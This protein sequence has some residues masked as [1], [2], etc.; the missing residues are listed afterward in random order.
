MDINEYC[1]ALEDV[2]AAMMSAGQAIYHEEC[3]TVIYESVANLTAAYQRYD[4]I[5]RMYVNSL[6]ERDDHCLR[7]LSDHEDIT[8]TVECMQADASSRGEPSNR[9]QPIANEQPPHQADQIGY[10]PTQEPTER[11]DGEHTL[12][13][14]RDTASLSPK[15]ERERL[16]SEI[17]FLTKQFE[18]EERERQLVRDRQLNDMKSRLLEITQQVDELYTTPNGSLKSP[19]PTPPCQDEQRMQDDEIPRWRNESKVENSNAHVDNG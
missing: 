6:P 2:E 16:E 9:P 4:S 19:S 5:T 12:V 8:A 13:K 1:I 3:E 11:L 17:A 10:D 18:I 15:R 14:S 7:V